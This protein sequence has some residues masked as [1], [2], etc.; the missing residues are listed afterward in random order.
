MH[1]SAPE[2]GAHIGR[3]LS[4]SGSFWSLDLH[5]DLMSLFSH[6]TPTHFA[7]AQGG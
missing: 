6:P 5:Q 2:H 7:F 3:P 4:V 1:T